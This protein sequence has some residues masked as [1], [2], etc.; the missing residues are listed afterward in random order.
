MEPLWTTF[1]TLSPPLDLTIT[2]VLY[3]KKEPEYEHLAKTSFLFNILTNQSSDDI[4][5]YHL[6]YVSPFAQLSAAVLLVFSLPFVF[7]GR[8]SIRMFAAVSC[9]CLF[10]DFRTFVKLNAVCWVAL[11]HLEIYRIKIVTLVAKGCLFLLAGAGF[12]FGL[13]DSNRLLM[14]DLMLHDPL[15]VGCFVGVAFML[16][17]MSINVQEKL[18]T[19]IRQLEKDVERATRYNEPV[20]PFK[21]GVAKFSIELQLVLSFAVSGLLV[22]VGKVYGRVLLDHV[23]IAAQVDV[24]KV[25]RD[26]ARLVFGIKYTMYFVLGGVWINM[27]DTMGTIWI[28][29]SN[30]FKLSS[31]TP[32][33][34]TFKIQNP[35][36][37]NF[38]RTLFAPAWKALW[39]ATDST[40]RGSRL[41]KELVQLVLKQYANLMSGLA[42]TRTA[43]SFEFDMELEVKNNFSFN[44]WQAEE[45]L[46][47]E[48]FNKDT[49]RTVQ[50]LDA[51]FSFPGDVAGSVQHPVAREE[52]NSF[53]STRSRSN[54][55][56]AHAASTTSLQ[57]QPSET[58]IVRVH[59][60]VEVVMKALQM[61]LGLHDRIHSRNAKRGKAG[62]QGKRGSYV[63]A[64][65]SAS[66]NV[67]RSAKG[68]ASGF[69]EKG[70]V[71]GIN[72][73]FDSLS[74]LDPHTWWEGV[75]TLTFS[76]AAKT[77]A[78]AV[79]TSKY[80]WSL[81][82]RTPSQSLSIG[83]M[84]RNKLIFAHPGSGGSSGD[85][86]D[87]Q[88]N[89]EGV[90]AG[91]LFNKVL[92]D[93]PV[94]WH[95]TNVFENAKDIPG[96]KMC[97]TLMHDAV[98]AT[99][100]DKLRLCVDALIDD[101]DF[102]VPPDNLLNRVCYV[103]LGSVVEEAERYIVIDEFTQS[104]RQLRQRRANSRKPVD[105]NALWAQLP[106]KH[107]VNAL[108]TSPH[109]LYLR[110]LELVAVQVLQQDAVQEFLRRIV[111]MGV[112]E[113]RSH[114]FSSSVQLLGYGSTGAQGMQ[115][116]L[117]FGRSAA[118]CMNCVE[119]PGLEGRIPA[120]LPVLSR[121]IERSPNGLATP[122]LFRVPADEV[123][124]KALIALAEKNALSE[125]FSAQA[126]TTPTSGDRP[127]EQQAHNAASLIKEWYRR[128]PLPL[129]SAFSEFEAVADSAQAWQIVVDRLEPNK[130]RVSLWLLR[131]LHDVV[132]AQTSLEKPMSA[133]ALGIVFAPCLFPC[134]LAPF[135]EKA[136]GD[137]LL[138]QQMLKEAL[139]RQVHFIRLLI[140]APD[141][142]RG[143]AA[144]PT[145]TAESACDDEKSQ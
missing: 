102:E 136:A 79:R 90:V 100:F 16:G 61:L 46:V 121:A 116:P 93:S 142:L 114:R 35:K 10:F 87:A 99:A 138:V 72:S 119:V 105:P 109:R 29:M 12:V 139:D 83:L 86:N 75:Q 32:T 4:D 89:L 67:A 60:R 54:S 59:V 133:H 30:K 37:D 129:F 101:L 68:S 3:A 63:D 31:T 124:K 57:F 25:T 39:K 143:C 19:Y 73:M 137:L 23:L 27:I 49:E 44:I 33:F 96:L 24:A 134:D 71:K 41:F 80:Q 110:S 141:P 66:E 78:A 115:D 123:N 103:L 130:R 111:T 2:A 70:L 58:K 42:D 88:R 97:K 52:A 125:M 95:F 128:L 18:G 38:I 7:S 11:A 21:A 6:L 40:A 85:Q 98:G 65:F 106:S 104:G 55:S 122:G 28:Y 50:F 126:S 113:W 144:A 118:H 48:M 13:T 36:V 81:L 5:L 53:Q 20:K 69:K 43:F 82:L 120:L 132:K 14:T 22:V 51:H 74:N 108:L 107:K 84:R 91:E 47:L 117:F 112:K 76:A 17:I 135:K 92:G 64:L 94:H 8:I 145:E 77:M 9:L 131:L 45:H 140:E 34:S 26:T 127:D 1:A 62:H 15:Y 56:S